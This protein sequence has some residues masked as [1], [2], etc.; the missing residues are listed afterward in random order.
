ME[1]N[2]GIWN[3]RS[4]LHV[5]QF[6]GHRNIKN[7]LLYTQLIKFE[8]E[9]DFYCAAA[10]TSNEAKELIES[11]FEYVCTTPESLMLFRKRK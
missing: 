1:G 8:K 4:I 9:D 7:T 11:G 2:N 5:M 3:T 6:L 10:R